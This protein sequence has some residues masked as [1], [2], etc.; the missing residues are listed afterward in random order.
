[1]YSITL[2]SWETKMIGQV[3]LFLQVLDQI[4][5]LGAY[6]DVEGGD[7]FVGDD[8]TGVEGEGA[9]NADA[10][11]L[12]AA[13]GV[14]VAAHVFGAQ[15]D[16]GEERC[17]AVLQFFA[18]GDI[19][20]FE[21]VADDVDNRHAWIE[22]V[23]GVLKDHAQLLTIRLHL[24]V[25]QGS[26]V[27]HFAVMILEEY[28]AAGEVVGAQDAAAG[29]CFAAAALADQAHGLALKDVEG[30]IIDSLDMADRAAEE[31]G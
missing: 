5:D 30:D 10:L 28:L 19:V 21:G 23:E 17:D 14:G 2:R 9:G 24:I 8:E 3:V 15:A 12:A 1:M 4:E 20:D 13:E 25:G 11:A 27:D 6:G 29:C 31:A 22:G 16:T 18:G 7:G 26:Q